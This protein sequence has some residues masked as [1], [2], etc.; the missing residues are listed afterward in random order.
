MQKKVDITPGPS[1]YR[2]EQCYKNE[3]PKFV[4]GIKSHYEVTSAKKR[5]TPGA[6][7]YNVIESS[8]FSASNKKA[9]RCS[10]GKEKR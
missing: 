8:D 6:G 5:T 7:A 2:K 9:P 10:F 3:G 1:H 4:I